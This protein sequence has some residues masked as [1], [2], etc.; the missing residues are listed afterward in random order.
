MEFLH[1]LLKSGDIFFQIVLAVVILV[2]LY[3]MSMINTAIRL[4]QYKVS[5]I[6]NDIKIISEEIKMLS[7]HHQPSAL[8]Q[9]SAP[10]ETEAAS[11]D[12]LEFSPEGDEP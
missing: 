8:D 6:D 3:A 12:D 11:D 7:P 9:P 1:F 5:G 4:L 10:P 2:I